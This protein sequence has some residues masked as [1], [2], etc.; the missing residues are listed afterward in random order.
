MVVTSGA[1]PYFLATFAGC[2]MGPMSRLA[3]CVVVFLLAQHAFHAAGSLFYYVSSPKESALCGIAFSGV[4]N[5]I[6]FL[7][8][9]VVVP[10]AQM[11]PF[12]RGIA[13]LLPGANAMGLM[14]FYLFADRP[15]DCDALA[16]PTICSDGDVVVE[17]F[18]FEKFEDRVGSAVAVI[19]LNYVLARILLLAI[20]IRS[21]CRRGIAPFGS[22]PVDDDGSSM[23][24]DSPLTVGSDNTVWSVRHAESGSPRLWPGEQPSMRSAE[25]V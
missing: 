6:I 21:A 12:W 23:G 19:I 10:L 17:H 11:P 4:Y 20:L 18:G 15:F 14:V 25:A 16:H 5:F 7:L 3:P 2:E 13:K 1:T 9:G 8:A 24:P 22:P